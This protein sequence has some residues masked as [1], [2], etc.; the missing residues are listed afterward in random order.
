MGGG[1]RGV[2]GGV[3]IEHHH[4]HHHHQRNVFIYYI[5]FIYFGLVIKKRKFKTRNLI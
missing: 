3:T 4:H 5:G 1:G 2:G